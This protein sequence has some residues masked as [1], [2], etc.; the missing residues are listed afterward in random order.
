MPHLH[1]PIAQRES[2]VDDYHGT[3][4][5]DPYRW[6]EDTNA[7]STK[8]W[9]AAENKV[10]FSFLEK[11]PTRKPLVNRLTTLWN[12]ERF[13]RP[14]HRGDHYFYT[15]NNGLQNQS[16]LYVADSLTSEPVVL[17]DPNTWS[18]EGTEALASWVPSLDGKRL[19][20]AVASAGSDWRAWFVLDV[21]TGKKL[22][23]HIRWSKFSGASWAADNSGFYY[24][25]YD[26]PEAGAEFSGTNYHQ[27]LYFHKVGDSQDQDQLIYERSDEK[28][29]GFGGHVT[30][31]GNYLIISIWKGTLRKNQIFYLDLSD[32]GSEVVELISGFDADYDF[33]GN[34]G[35]QFWL[36]TDLDAPRKR[37]INIDLEKSARQHWSNLI[38]EAEHKL[39]SVS[40][41][42][43]HFVV[44]YLQHA[45]NRV[46]V[47]SE[48]GDQIRE[49]KL[50]DV[51]STGGFGGR[52][53]DQDTFYTFTNYV[54]PSTIYR[55][56]IASGK[57]TIYRQPDVDFDPSDYQTQQHFIPSKDGTKIPLFITSKRGLRHDGSHPTILYGYGGF[58]I[59]LT[60]GFSVSNLVWL[61]MGGVYVVANLRGGGEYGSDWHESGMQENKQNVFDDFISCA[62]WLIDEKITSTQNLA[63]RGGSNG[64]LLVGAC[65]TQRPELFGAALPAVGVMDML[66]YHRFTIGWAWVSEFGSADD[67]QQF[68][69]LIKYSPLHNLKNKTR[70]PA[71]LVTTADHDD[72]V[73]P[74]HSFKFAAQLQHA[75]RGREP[76]LIRIES[77][78]GHGAGTPTTKRIQAAAD[79][80]AFLTHVLKYDRWQ[81][82]Q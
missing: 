9:V 67:K 6:L 72:R 7:E 32:P 59:S 24:S 29:W 30:E 60:P 47:Y 65:M 40:N 80:W 15:S 34:A 2:T 43:E 20:Y 56:D 61:E 46:Y 58:D 77:S 82:E 23:D 79:M 31:D 33:V 75:H 18:D 64:G 69:T 50:P 44:Q 3:T 17:I 12:Y 42:G 57:S 71:T 62:E 13:G 37:L 27:K 1:Y 81:L 74:G 63:I 73:V 8:Q 25:A 10:T 14:V 28:E 19:A 52:R 4:V 68:E 11:I 16:I 26:P 38:P 78:A 21:E 36:L 39:E 45:Q 22:T 54:T 41:V 53:D 51:G 55:Y 70:Y 49:V 76:V 5:P 48:S 66:R 35:S